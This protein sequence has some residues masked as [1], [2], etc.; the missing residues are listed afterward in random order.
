MSFRFLLFSYFATVFAISSFSQSVSTEQKIDS[1]LAKMSIEEKIGQLVLKGTSSRKNGLSEEIK[2]EV[3]DGKLGAMLN[4]SDPAL[5]LQI[6]K[7]AVEESPNHI[8]LI[9]GRDV[10]HGYKTIFP[11]PLGLT[12]SWDPSLAEQSSK[13]AAN[14][15]YSRCINWTFAPMVDICRDARWGRIAES[16]GE[17]P[18]LAS[19]FASAYIKGF[20]G[21]DLSDPGNI[22][23][24]TKHYA[25]YG[26]AEG[27]RDYNTANMPEFILRNFYLK[28]FHATV[29]AGAGTFMTSFNDLNGIPA[30]ANEFLLK[31]VL[32][33]EWKYDGFVVS[34]WNSVTEMIPHGFSGNE[35]DAAKSSIK[36]GLD[37]EMN[38]SAYIN[39]LKNL[40]DAGAIT[41]KDIDDR[42]RNILRIKLRAGLFDSPYFNQKD[43]FKLYA[44]PSLELAKQA[45]IKSCVLLKNDNA[46]LP[47]NAKTKVAVIGPLANAPLDQLGTWIYDGEQDHSI[48]PLTS[49]QKQY[50]KQVKYAAGT[51][52]SRSKETT[53]FKAAIEIANQLDVILFFGGEEAILSGE[54]HSRADIRLPGSQEQLIHELHKTGKPIVLILMAGRPIT[55]EAILPEVDAVMMAWHPGTMAGPAITDLISGKVSPSGKL[56][57]TWPITVGQIPIYYNHTNTGRPA[58]SSTYI[59]INDIPIGAW[60]SSLGN[61]SHYLDAGF[62]P[63][64]PFGYGLTYSS[65]KLK[66][67]TINKTTFETNDSISVSVKIENTGKVAITETVQL[68]IR[69]K[70]GSVV[71]PV[72]E[73]KGFEQVSLKAKESKTVKITIPIS[74]LAFYNSRLDYKVEKGDF[75]LWLSTSSVGGLTTDFEVK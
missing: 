20:Q 67:L 37:M 45:A 35:K 7:I 59:G 58:D 73:L 21:A 19:L 42:V 10:I 6:Q 74:D 44:K 71:R 61:E 53:G 65:T 64:Y 69:D 9:F 56:P 63:L 28:P 70:V 54:A 11:I 47:L 4:L 30:S 60:Q 27:G 3:R 1:L 15:A 49:L 31:D 13:V 66:D 43:E 5:V 2:Q 52:H 75:Q 17:D 16:P 68:Y 51:S 62:H 50:G 23:A 12:A 34:D 55:M 36:A 8:P 72:K 29:K 24:C 40:L 18:F 26:A 48:T 14:E 57:V 32:R 41:V 22:I 25:A 38:S 33:D 39:E 46:I